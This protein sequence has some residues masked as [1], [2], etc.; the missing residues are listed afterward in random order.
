MLLQLL[1]DLELLLLDELLVVEGIYIIIIDY[2]AAGVDVGNNGRYDTSNGGYVTT[3]NS[4][5]QHIIYNTT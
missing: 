3:K 2:V 5:P 4:G 1:L